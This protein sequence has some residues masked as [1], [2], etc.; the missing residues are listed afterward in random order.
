MFG[1]DETSFFVLPV[2]NQINGDTT[3]WLFGSKD[4]FLAASEPVNST[5]TKC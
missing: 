5:K 4:N 1:G 2:L 3:G